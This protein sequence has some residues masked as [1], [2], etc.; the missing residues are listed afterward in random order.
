MVG[1]IF[2]AVTNCR[3]NY[4]VPSKCYRDCS[5][6]VANKSPG[7]LAA[8]KRDTRS[9]G[10]AANFVERLID[11]PKMAAAAIVLRAAC[12]RTTCVIPDGIHIAI[13]VRKRSLARMAN[14]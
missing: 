1:V 2:A 14:S 12:T 3:G 4:R 5:V 8:S 13:R 7:S 6:Q 9:A 11:D 10:R